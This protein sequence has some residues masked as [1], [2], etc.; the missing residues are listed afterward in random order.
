[1]NKE[2]LKIANKEIHK[3]AG[4]V[5]EIGI[6]LLFARL[7]PF[8]SMEKYNLIIHNYIKAINPH[9]GEFVGTKEEL[10]QILDM[11]KWQHDKFA[12]TK[13]E[14]KYVMAEFPELQTHNGFIYHYISEKR[15]S[16]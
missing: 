2:E 1:M 15:K 9:Q 4:D 12:D 6:K 10:I 7:N 16:K 14:I 8:C 13:S 3:K 5:A 11:M